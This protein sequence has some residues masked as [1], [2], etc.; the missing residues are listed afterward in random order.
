MKKVIFTTFV[1]ILLTSPG[2]TPDVGIA[3]GLERIGLYDPV[4]EA[5]K[6][7]VRM[8]RNE[9]EPFQVVIQ[10][11]QNVENCSVTVTDLHDEEGNLF[12]QKNFTLYTVH[13]LYVKTPSP[14]SKAAP[15]WYPDGLIPLE[16][17]D[18]KK[19]ENTVIWVDIY[20][21]EDQDPGVYT[22]LIS[23]DVGEVIEVPV[24]VEVWGFTLPEKTTLKSAVEVMV[25][26][27]IEAHGLS[28]EPEELEPVLYDYYETL[29]EH[30]VMPWELYFSEPEVFRDGSIDM[31]YNHE[32]LKYFMDVLQVNSLAYPMYED[33][34]FKSPFGRDLEKTTE[35]LRELYAYY[36]KNGWEDRFF[37]FIIDEPNSRIAYQE[38]RDVSEKLEE[39]NPDI[40]FLV[41]EQMVPDDPSWGDLFGYVDIWCP[42]FPCIEEEKELIE[43]RQ[44]LG[45]EVWTY[46]ALTQGEKETP[47]WEL[48]FP[49]L[50]YRVTMWMIW[51]SE[52]TGLIYWTCNWWEDID[53]PW[54]D[55]ETW[56]EDGEV[57]NGEGILVYPGEEGCLPSIRLKILREGMED[58]EYFVL[59]ESLGEKSFADKEVQKIV[60]S[61]YQWDESPQRM[62]EVRRILGEEIDRITT[63]G[64][65]ELKEESETGEPPEEQ[66]EKEEQETQVDYP[67][68]KEEKEVP[69]MEEFGEDIFELDEIWIYL[70]VVGIVGGI[71]LFWKRKG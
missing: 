33:W 59:L 14:R 61:W 7:Y 52:I 42:L 66:E 47:F 51:N 16:L 70:L 49:V 17:F 62:L 35:Y 68:E 13:Y 24:T 40:R 54:V 58:Y 30:R 5:Q 60:K 43:E 22:G 23:I 55:T 67:E 15:G 25:Y 19:G 1:V 2:L 3:H 50:N 37:F 31:E 39:I 71:L 10:S 21:P 9:Y 27:I 46:T 44:T 48:D 26:L 41:T 32:H 38:V 36:V 8:A 6:V 11:Q 69:S 64:P 34:P 65:E 63:E 29:I 53:D 45:E 57:Y 12:S 20:A 18:V 56:T 4:P 28:W